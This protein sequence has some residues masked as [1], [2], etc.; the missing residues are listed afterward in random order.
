VADDGI[1]IG[2]VHADVY[3]KTAKD[4]WAK[5]SAENRVGAARAG[6]D[7]GDRIGKAISA[8]IGKAVRDGLDGTG[9]GVQG[10][11]A[12]AEYGGRFGDAVRARLEKALRALPTPQIG[13]ATTEA[14]QKVRD[15]R[16][17]I[18]TLRS[19]KIGIDISDADALAELRRIQLEL[20][21]LG[22]RSPSIQVRTDLGTA[23][24]QLAAITA[25]AQQVGHLNP[26]IRVGT[27]ARQA[28]QEV[29][30][31][32]AA[33]F[34]IGPAIIPGA[35]AAAG[36]ILAIGS[37]ATS[38]LAG[39]GV[40]ALAFHGVA[41]AVKALDTAQ[42]D[43]AKTGST[44]ASQQK[45]LAGGADQVRSAEA[46]LANTRANASDAL[47]RASR[48]VADARRAEKQAERDLA[49][50]REQEARS[51]QDLA[52]QAKGNAIDQRQAVLDLAD[53]RKRAASG[54]EVDKIAAEQAELRLENLRIAGK[55]LADEKARN[56]KT[57]VE[58]SDAV[59]AA[60]QRVA[61]AT[62]AV[63]D[64]QTQQATAARQAAFQIQQAS[65]AVVT[66]QRGIGAAAVAAGATGGAAMDGL[67]DAMDRLSP[68]GQRF[69]RFLFGLKSNVDDL[70]ASA[71][72]GILPGAQEAITTLL[73]YFGSLDRSVGGI[74]AK[75]GELE[76]RAAKTLTNPFWRGFF[77]FIA[78]EANP[79][80]E[81]MFRTSLNVAEGL[82]RIVQQFIPVERQV[83]GGILT[84]S[85]RFAD[86]SRTL[87]QNQGFQRFVRFV[88]AEG[89][90]VVATI[91]ELARAGLHV[92]EA[93]APVGSV[94]ATELKLLASIINAIPVPVITA[95]AFAITAYKT[96][97]LLTSGAQTLLNS[98]LL[99]GGARMLGF[100]TATAT[101]TTSASAFRTGV[102]SVSSFIGGPFLAGFTIALGIIG[103]FVAA[104]E[105][106]RSRI[107]AL[108]AAA[109]SYA[110]TLKDGT[111]PAAAEQARQALAQNAALRDLVRTTEAAGVQSQTLVKGLNGDREARG[112]VVAAINKQIEAEKIQQRQALANSSDDKREAQAHADRIKQLREMAKAFEGQNSAMAESADLTRALAEAGE[113]SVGALDAVKTALNGAGD[114]VD[115]YRS[116][117]ER[118][119]G[120][121]ADAASKAEVLALMSGRVADANL[122]AADKTSLF[123]DI[124]SG[125]GDSASN[126]GPVFDN[127]A[128]AFGNIAKSSIDARDKVRLLNQA[129]E[130][131]YGTAIDQVE[132]D[133]KLARTQ[134]DLTKQLAT[135]SAGFDLNKGKQRGNTEE[136]LRNRDALEAALLAARDKYVQDVANGVSEDKA[137]DTHDKTVKSIMNGIDPTQRQTAAVKDLAKKYGDIPPKVT[138]DV[139][140]PGLDKAIDDLIEAHAVQVGLAMKPPWTK[141]QIKSEIDFLKGSVNGQTG[142][143]ARFKADGGP[144]FGPG[145][146][147]S[148][149]VPAYLPE[150]GTRYR[151][152]NDEHI[153]TAA[154]VKAAGGHGN[155]YALRKT[156]LG[157][158]LKG[159]LPG[160]AK[161]GAVS[162]TWPVEIPSNVVFPVSVDSL[163]DAWKA[164]TR[165]Q[166]IGVNPNFGPGPGFPPWPSSPAASRGDSGVWRSIVA[167]IRSTGPLSGSFGNAYRAGDPLWHGSGRSVDWM[168]YEQDALATFLAERRPLELIH[169]TSKRDYAYTRG[170]DRGSFNE[171]L[172]QAHRNHIHIAMASG[173][174]VGLAQ[175]LGVPTT[176]LPLHVGTYDGGGVL[177]PGL[178]LAYNGTRGNETV[179]TREQ[180]AAL[181][182]P[183]PR[184]VVAIDNFYARSDDPYD[185][186][187]ELDWLSRGRG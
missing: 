32:V 145:T 82:A 76:V 80:L 10:A 151:L 49:D 16:N 187:R 34:A 178:T 27:N 58:G 39:G 150:T 133:E 137:R 47:L 71:E 74:S 89:P 174:Q 156:I 14:E 165:P 96:A 90:H 161:G 36:A 105:E 46:S 135:S 20:A 149:D 62:Q 13:A 147:T 83:G 104:N 169:R 179:R 125:I 38:A 22:R 55:R 17:S 98:G 100:S 93:Y 107:E 177:R 53:A 180:E 28:A 73:P 23:S 143:S 123:A 50:V 26:Q 166:G 130:Q 112:Q 9:I 132:V 168:G 91:G 136:V 4:A 115:A 138:T 120:F 164:A 99:A 84:I 29:N 78:S 33:G 5:W 158:G 79:N 103:A 182:T 171:G 141:D 66:A 122:D 8:R 70:K 51:Q 134:S 54:T 63:K 128:L 18:D 81:L 126:S 6:E 139:S 160:F 110:Q 57:G 52:Q 42:Q 111:G 43:A 64:A 155:I 77:G 142:Q 85:E 173:G 146:G 48:Q 117:I 2:D 148:D 41:D 11:R 92:V 153:L 86:W 45:S 37:A 176:R 113:D 67:A 121:E 25:Q 7:L 59:R 3:L 61:D 124:L 162:S 69:A 102:A 44:L 30:L 88:L 183:Q 31:L 159:V 60:Q 97:A 127:L 140:T 185:V 40:A 15:L 116:G 109:A 1:S 101:A 94:V 19:Q 181:A 72:G 118:L 157:G 35:I 56:D 172:M 186:A 106:A 152:S 87:D 119:A 144:V 95:L 175:H 68:S 65:Q 167:L 184:A 21:E 170:R 114:S 75:L 108:R 163:W 129:V 154:E 12:G 24:A 131:M